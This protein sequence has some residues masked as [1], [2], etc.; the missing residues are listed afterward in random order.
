M[1]DP[2]DPEAPSLD[3]AFP[4]YGAANP[5][6]SGGARALSGVTLRR[7]IS[8]PRLGAPR[9]RKE[10]PPAPEEP[11]TTAAE[12]QPEVTWFEVQLVDEKG[13]A[14]AGARYKVELPDGSPREG[15]LD[16][17]GRLR[18]DA[19]PKGECKVTFPDLEK[20]AA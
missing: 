8:M 1:A 15:K 2:S 3:D 13:D 12:K 18:L 20:S 7:S 9:A 4:R 17:R 11:A 14:L 19:I 16:G 10:A 5:L 6:R